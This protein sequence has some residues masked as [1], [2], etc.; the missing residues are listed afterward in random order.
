MEVF[1][2]PGTMDYFRLAEG[3]LWDLTP[4]SGYFLIIRDK[5]YCPSSFNTRRR[6]SN[7]LER[8]RKLC[9]NK[10]PFKF[11][12]PSICVLLRLIYQ[13]YDLL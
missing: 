12:S 10:C 6:L 2:K 4:T 13:M 7:L 5:E 9:N 3:G 11:H 8:L 1:G